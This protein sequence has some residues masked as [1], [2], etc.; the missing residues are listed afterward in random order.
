M[1]ARL[2]STHTHPPVRP[3]ANTRTRTQPPC[4]PP[5]PSQV[6]F[7][8]SPDTDSIITSLVE[9][10]SCHYQIVVRTPRLCKHPAFQEEPTPVSVI[11]CYPLVPPAEEEGGGG[12]AGQCAAGGGEGTCTAGGEGG[13]EGMSATITSSSVIVTHNFPTDDE[14]EEEEGGA[15]DRRLLKSLL[16]RQNG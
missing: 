11:K 3:P 13:V 16:D 10:R 4:T 14:E 7:Q 1:P 9:P 12:G 15:E 2:V 5:P 6:R 8:C